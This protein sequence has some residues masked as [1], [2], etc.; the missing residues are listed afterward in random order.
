VFFN[1]NNLTDEPQVSYQ[2]FKRTDNPE[3]ITT[4]GWRATTG[5]SIR[6]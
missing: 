1:V 6:F 3:D 5:V 2:G 4:Y